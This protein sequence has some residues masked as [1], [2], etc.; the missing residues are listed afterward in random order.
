MRR[1][2]Y[3]TFG[4]AC[5]AMFLGVFLYLMGFVGNLVVARSIDAPTAAPP[6]PWPVALLVDLLLLALFAVPH[7]VMARPGFKRW[8]TRFVP[9]ELERSVYVLIANLCVIALIVGWRPIG[10]IVWDVEQPV[11]RAALWA[12][13]VTG[14]LLVPAASLLINHFDL[15]GSRQ[16]WL[17]L[18]RK[19]YAPPPFRTPLPYR[20]VRHP[21]YVGW[22][23]AF[24]ATPTM[25]A[26]HLLFAAFLT[27]YILVAI[28]FE[29]RDLADQYSES[30]VR[31]RARTPMLIPGLRPAG[32]AAADDAGI[33][34]APAAQPE[35]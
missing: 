35:S 22:I 6:A 1:L 18:R 28:A 19:P 30:Y 10:A 23:V 9:T 7:S 33:P 3:F 27:G 8:W 21:L 11:A 2:A 26:G 12:L 4:A 5:H 20:W 15:F 13:F 32:A 31:Y 29:E 14:W 25:S 17:Y 34:A 24:W 16:T